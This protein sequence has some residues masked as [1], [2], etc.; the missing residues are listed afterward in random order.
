M[1]VIFYFFIQTNFTYVALP[2]DTL[3]HEMNEKYLLFDYKDQCCHKCV[4]NFSSKYDNIEYLSYNKFDSRNCAS[5]R[6]KV[7]FN[8]NENINIYL[9]EG[10][11]HNIIPTKIIL[12]GIATFVIYIG[13][14]K[15]VDKTKLNTLK[16]YI[17]DF[18]LY[19]S[20]SEK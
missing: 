16:K 2:A 7:R 3:E 18:F 6:L 9:L 4:L 8:L 20:T 15:D 10:L 11:K 1:I 5:A 17:E 19:S 13:F 12:G 14:A